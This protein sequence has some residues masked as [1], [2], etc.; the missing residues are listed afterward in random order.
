MTNH[1]S[2]ISA[3]WNRISPDKLAAFYR[4]IDKSAGPT[5]CWL[6]TGRLNPSGYGCSARISGDYLAHRIIYTL[7][8]GPIPDG[9]CVLHACDCRNCVNP[10]HLWL[11]TRS[12]N[13]RDRNEKGRTI[14]SHC[15]GL[16]NGKAY[17][18]DEQ[19]NEIRRRCGEG[20]GP[21]DIARDMG[22]LR[23]TVANI[24][25]G[26]RRIDP[27]VPHETKNKP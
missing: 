7:E 6:W 13:C 18:T 16:A 15:Y 23:T 4:L 20:E 11:G 25:Y 21:P 1:K 9:L 5:G 14:A 2:L 3:A 27:R 10:A 26:R 12:D 22:L 24:A 19:V 8:V 17:I